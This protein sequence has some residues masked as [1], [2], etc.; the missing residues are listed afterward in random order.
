MTEEYQL[1][2]IQE[3]EEYLEA[4]E[5]T[6]VFMRSWLPQ[7]EIEHITLQ[8]HGS[9]SH[10]GAHRKIALALC[11]QKIATFA[12]DMRGFGLNT[13]NQFPKLRYAARWALTTKR[14]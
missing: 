11:E 2:D 14:C 12:I 5:G 1:K 13:F 6:R 8:M 10:S 4:K 9:A 3:H 7:Q